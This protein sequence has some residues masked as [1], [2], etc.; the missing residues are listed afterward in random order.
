LSDRGYSFRTAPVDSLQAVI[1][2]Q[3]ATTDHSG[4]T[5]AT[6]YAAGDY[7]RQLSG[8]FSASFDGEIQEQVPFSP[9]DDIYD[10]PLSEALAGEPDIL[11]VIGYPDS[12]IPLLQTYYDQY[13][14][15]ELLFLSDG[16][17]DETVSTNVEFPQDVYGAIPASAGPGQEAFVSLYRDEYNA[18]PG[19]FAAN[20]YDAAATIL[21]ANAAAGQNSGT[22]IAEQMTEVTVA[23]GTEIKPGELSEGIE[24]AAA[25]EQVQYR[26]AS[27]EIEFDKNGDGGSVQYE[28]VRFGN[29][30][31]ESIETLTPS[32]VRS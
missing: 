12:G 9:D 7:G 8:A 1:V 4:D 27:G 15:D 25:G 17:V 3:L 2:A 21:L 11:F 19:L 26:G 5:A 14:D 16:L 22:A 31:R 30:G 28:Y 29:S 20:S 24:R 6:L 18:D 23:E 10:D 13:A 32:E